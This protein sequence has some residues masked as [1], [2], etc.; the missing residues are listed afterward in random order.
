MLLQH[1]NTSI[2]SSKTFVGKYNKVFLSFVDV[3]INIGKI[4]YNNQF[5]FKF[6]T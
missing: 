6:K 2:M 4:S 5:V 1:E 3:G